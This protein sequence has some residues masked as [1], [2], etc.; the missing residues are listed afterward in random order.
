[1][2]LLR[3]IATRPAAAPRQRT[4]AL[5]A[6]VTIDP[7]G[8]E[9][10]AGDVM[11]DPAAPIELREA[12]AGLLAAID[13][14]RVRKLL[15]ETLPLAPERLQTAIAGG[16]ARRKDGATAL[17]D[18]IAA[19]QAWARLLQEPRIAFTMMAADPPHLAERMKSLLAGLP[20]ADQK[21]GALLDRRR[22]GY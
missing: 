6:L 11:R 21:L 9:A 18:A 14:P 7:T 1:Q 20:P 22:A 16:L 4:G 13:R 3:A 17:L 5:T 10:L 2:G 12:A 8:N 19:G 15:I